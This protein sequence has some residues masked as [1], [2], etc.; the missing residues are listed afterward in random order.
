MEQ[1]RRTTSLDDF[2]ETQFEDALDVLCRAAR[3]DRPRSDQGIARLTS[4]I[5]RQLGIRL[6][7][8]ADRKK[9]TEIPRQEINNP[10]I[11]IGLPRSGTTILHSLLAQDPAAR[12]PQRWEMTHPF[13]PPRT[14][15]YETDPRIALV[16]AE[17][18][19]FDPEFRAMH[20]MA[21]TLPE[22]CNSLVEAS[23]RTMNYWAQMA[24]PSYVQWLLN[25]SAMAPAYAFHRQFLQHLQA[26]APREYWVLKAPP[27]IFWPDCLLETYPDARIVMTHRDPKQV[28]PSNASLIAQV[29]AASEKVNA[30]EVGADQ[31]LWKIGLQRT[32]ALRSTWPRPE[33]FIDTYYKDF[34]SDPLQV[35]RQIYDH[36]GMNLSEEAERRMRRFMASNEKEKHGK[37]V[38]TAEQFGLTPEII[39]EEFSEYIEHFGLE[40]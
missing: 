10:I 38:Y 15:T 3:E 37:H 7:L 13:P 8:A 32:M 6:K 30:R 34:I 18:E 14:E 12:S 31:L 40:D 2:G 20:R 23:F 29:R 19:T 16:D 1:A 21:A 17:I 9:Y 39:R 25:D 28:L 33:Q 36:F 26:F 24:L 11:L 35:V 5:E 4:N 27:H 22:E